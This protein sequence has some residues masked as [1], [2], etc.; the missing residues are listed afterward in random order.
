MVHGIGGKT[1]SIDPTVFVAW[2]AE[3]AGAA[4]IAKDA[5]VW[6][7]TTVRADVASIA[8]GA[9]SNLQDG[10]IVHVDGDA[11]TTVGEDVTVGH[12]AILHGCTI[13]DACLI[14]MG[15]TV[16]S[17]AELGPGCIVGAGALV[18]QGKK[19]PARSL[20][21]GVP[22]KAIRQVYDEEAA[23]SLDNARRYV[24]NAKKALEGGCDR[25]S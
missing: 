22:A 12:G 19:F 25:P 18:T 7:G 9:R 5:S 2:N 6:F 4:T 17:H 1:P 15:A 13:G 24:V 11:P 14:G 20:I 3:I 10:V 16:L 21:V 23:R 8:I